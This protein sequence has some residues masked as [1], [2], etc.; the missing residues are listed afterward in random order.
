[1]MPCVNV[2]ITMAQGVSAAE[3]RQAA[4]A[5]FHMQDADRSGS[6]NPVEFYNALSSLGL[7]LTW[8]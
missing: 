2:T 7:G 8:V 1:M 3:K 6:I 4:S 5:A